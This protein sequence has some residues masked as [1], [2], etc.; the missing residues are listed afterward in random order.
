MGVYKLQDVFGILDP[1]LHDQAGGA[2]F[3]IAD[4]LN[5]EVHEVERNHQ[6]RTFEQEL[7]TV[8]ANV[9]AFADQKI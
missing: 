5:D 6:R 7:E 4:V 3:R 9:V 8:E 1:T 2:L